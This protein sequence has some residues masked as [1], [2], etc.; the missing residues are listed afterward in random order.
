VGLP[1]GKL[2]RSDFLVPELSF[3]LGFVLLGFTG[4]L[5]DDL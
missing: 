4:K 5:D 3:K 2:V 1:K